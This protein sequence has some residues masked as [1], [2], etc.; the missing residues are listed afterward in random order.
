MKFSQS[1]CDIMS[2]SFLVKASA[3]KERKST[4]N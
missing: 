3:K 2:K 1:L 4:I